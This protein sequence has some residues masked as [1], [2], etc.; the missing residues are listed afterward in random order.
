MVPVPVKPHERILRKYFSLNR[1]G[2]LPIKHYK[3]MHWCWMW[4]SG[5]QSVFKCILNDVFSMVVIWALCRPLKF[6]SSNLGKTCLD[7]CY[8]VHRGIVRLERGCAAVKKMIPVKWNCVKYTI[9]RHI[10]YS[11]LVFFSET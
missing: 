6:F 3:I 7:G 10:V 5:V 9:Q 4:R 8:F 11:A 2:N 1:C